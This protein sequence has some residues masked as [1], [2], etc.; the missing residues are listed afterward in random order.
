MSLTEEV[1]FMGNAQATHLLPEKKRNQAQRKYM[2]DPKPY[3]SKSP[4]LP[5]AELTR[6]LLHSRTPSSLNPSSLQEAP[7]FR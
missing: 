1:Q 2:L 5:S 3:E 7:A 6:D 4:K